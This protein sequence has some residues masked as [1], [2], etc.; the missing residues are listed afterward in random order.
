MSTR[1][2]DG[3]QYGRMLMGGAALLA[4]HAEELNAMNVFPVSDGDTGSNMSRTLEGG[5]AKLDLER[6]GLSIGA[7][8]KKFARGA[9]LS[10]R[11]NSGVIL[12]QIFAGINEKLSAYD[13]AGALELAE[14][15][16]SGISKSYGAVQH[17]TEGTIL[18][19][20]R[21]S[22]EHAAGQINEDSTV[23]DFF[24]A[25]VEEGRRSLERTKDLLPV[26][27][28]SGVVDSGGAG[29]LYLAEGMYE[30]LTGK[31]VDYVSTQKHEQ[32]EVDIDRFTRDS[33]LEFGYCTEFFLRLMTAKVNPDAFEIGT[34]LEDL[35]ELGGESVV[36]YKQDDIVKV[37]VHTMTPGLILSRMQKYGEFL[38]VKIENMSLGHN[39]SVAGLTPDTPKIRKPFAVV[40]VA[41]GEGIAEEFTAL[42]ADLIIRSGPSENPSI[43]DFLEAFR[44]CESED[45]L[46]FPN[47]K[48]IMLAAN[49]A[50]RLYADAK[51]HVIECKSVMQGYSGLSVLTP[52]ITDVEELVSDAERAARDT[53]DF[54]ITRTVRDAEI[55]GKI[56]REGEYIAISRGKIA[57]DADTPEAAVLAALE[58]ADADLCELLTI[59][60]GKDVTEEKKTALLTALEEQFEDLEVVML[61]GG[62]EIYDYYAALE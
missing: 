52:G 32:A 54:E 19:V 53:A 46:V 8:S 42:G 5:L 7:T 4:A 24:E 44:R 51:V 28:E 45:I 57:A 15:Y 37:H 25:L 2:I 3:I 11:G 9:L 48:N 61:D 10:A 60:A 47:H 56:I 62:Q 55:E 43:E 17:P 38:T 33:I 14:A 50:A 1:S 20:F 58:T 29:Y 23:E 31:P 35:R 21:E 6:E 39:E 41:M 18:T 59:F 27:A 34:L 30:V 12:S 16:K 36:A 49:S 26:L 22:T 40:A 13:E